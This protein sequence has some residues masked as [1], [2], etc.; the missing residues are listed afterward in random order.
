MF[1]GRMRYELRHVK[2]RM[3][4]APR[5]T[6]GPILDNPHASRAPRSAG[7]VKIQM[8]RAPGWSVVGP[9]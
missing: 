5:A 2:I 8:I 6:E 7:D 4:C 1:L 9:Q 3:I